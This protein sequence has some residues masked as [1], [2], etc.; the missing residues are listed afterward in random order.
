MEDTPGYT[1]LHTP[2]NHGDTGDHSYS[3]MIR[4]PADGHRSGKLLLG[5]ASNVYYKFQSIATYKMGYPHN[6]L[7]LYPLQTLFVVGYT[8]FT[9]SVCPSVR[10]SVRDTLVFFL[11]S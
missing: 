10:V 11:I 5:S 1:S 9:L 6:I 3:Q 2:G 7:L 8:V 4:T